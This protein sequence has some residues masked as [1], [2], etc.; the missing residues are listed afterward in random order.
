MRDKKRTVANSLLKE[1]ATGE[2]EFMLTI[3]T[4]KLGVDLLAN[5]NVVSKRYKGKN[6]K[7]PIPNP[8]KMLYNNKLSSLCYEDGFNGK[9][10]QQL[11][12]QKSSSG[13]NEVIPTRYQLPV[14]PDFKSSGA[15]DSSEY[16]DTGLFPGWD[17]ESTMP[18]AWV[19][20]IL[21][22]FYFIPE[23]R[24]AALNS[25]IN[26]KIV[27]TKSY[28]KALV[29]ELGF[30][31]D[32]MEKISRYGLLY[33]TKGGRSLD[34]NSFRARIGAWFPSNILMFLATMPE[35]EQLQVLDGSPA[36]VD[37]PRRPE[38]FY[39][40]LAY[41][42][43][44]ELPTLASSPES[45]EPSTKLMD[46]LNGLDF[47]SSNQFIE[48]KSSPPTQTV[49]RA[50]T[51]DLNYDMFPP[52]AEK[53]PIRFGE[54]LQHS[55]CRETRLRAWNN[56]SRAYETIIQRKI[57]TSLP[58]ILTL[59]CSCAG[60][61]EEDGLWAWRT[62]IGNEPWLPEIVEVELLP[63]GNVSVTEWHQSAN[64]SG[65]TSTTFTGKGSL[66]DE[67]SK[68]VSDA[69]TKQKFRYR[70]DAVLSF[71]ADTDSEGYDDDEDIGHH[72]LHA[73]IPASYKRMLLKSQMEEA[74]KL[75]SKRSEPSSAPSE[76]Q[77]V[78]NLVLNASISAEEF[79]KR[80]E[81]VKET[82]LSLEQTDTG[83][84][85]PTDWILYNGFRVSNT[86]IEDARAFHVS[87]KEPVLVVYQA[88]D[89]N[90]VPVRD[91]A[92]DMN[93]SVLDPNLPSSVMTPRSLSSVTAGCNNDF[94]TTK[95]LDLIE[96]NRPIAFDAEFVSVQDEESTL[97]E[98][99]QKLVIRDTRYALGR[100]SVLDCPTK[101][102]VVDD[103]VLPREHVVD[104]LTRFSGIVADDLDPSKAKHRIISTRSAYL[105][106]RYLLERGC[107]F[108]GHGLKQDFGTVN[109]IVPPNQILDTVEIFHQPGMRYVSLRFL[110]NYVL[111]RDMQQDTHDS[112]EDAR[113]A[114]ELYQKALEWKKDGVWDQRLQEL[115]SYGEKT[116]WKLGVDK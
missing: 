61:K 91:V 12:G 17:Y 80:A 44:R 82:L 11:R 103:H 50:L 72:V 111:G 10:K 1:A 87:F 108:V 49:T 114:F 25:Q 24:A 66:P 21:L 85:E 7:D 101:E 104:Y 16:N 54:L 41:Q 70:L 68:L 71:V 81:Y 112:V 65:E 100:I 93:S 19:S 109:L 55:M 79:E 89:E 110:A 47:L 106:M 75:A 18:N 30:V 115:Y 9:R 76:V 34:T 53:P 64:G 94:M 37:R 102:I 96:E 26:D 83:K 69:S 56:K 2:N 6:I 105:E 23:I 116:S 67:V 46:S 22:L 43:D 97:A 45:K 62:N 4:T 95:G 36:A 31:F 32:Q 63:D 40:F 28:E 3:P 74:R 13:E 35:A 78:Q 59:S 42:F 39:R 14:R 15:F 29:P 107:I 99:G 38:S 57:A 92:D 88:V 33:P 86:V 5:H 84:E 27:G 60:R 8:N 52:G 113:A 98:S 73:R 77:E 90:S 58:R 20:P 51:L 48:S